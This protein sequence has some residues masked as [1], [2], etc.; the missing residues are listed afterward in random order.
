VVNKLRF[1]VDG[2]VDAT[3]VPHLVDKMSADK[4]ACSDGGRAISLFARNP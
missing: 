2:I 1:G 4:A 3:I